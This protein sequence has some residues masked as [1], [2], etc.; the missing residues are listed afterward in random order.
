MDHLNYKIVNSKPIID[1][2]I[3]IYRDSYHS[4]MS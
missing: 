2:K 4:A 3:L 1:K